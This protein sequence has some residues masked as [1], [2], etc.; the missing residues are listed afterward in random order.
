M[1]CKEPGC[2]GIHMSDE[3][4]EALKSECENLSSIGF[5]VM[6]V[7]REGVAVFADAR[8]KPLYEA[9]EPK[10]RDLGENLADFLAATFGT[11]PLEAQE[12]PKPQPVMMVR[13]PKDVS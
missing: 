4:A 8:Y 9:L 1:K 2:D 11:E 6:F 5:I 7:R 13:G 12:I 3:C 10:G